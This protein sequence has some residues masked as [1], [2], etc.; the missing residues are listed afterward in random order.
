MDIRV[1]HIPE[2]ENIQQ[3]SISIT[4][5][6]RERGDDIIQ[7]Y[8]S[9]FRQTEGQLVEMDGD[10]YSLALERPLRRSQPRDLTEEEIAIRRIRHPAQVAKTT[11][12]DPT[13]ELAKFWIQSCI[14]GHS[15]CSDGAGDGIYLP[16][17][18][19]DLGDPQVVRVI[20]T[21][22]STEDVKYLTLSHCWGC[23]R[24]PIGVPN[25]R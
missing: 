21:A 16:T 10:G 15:R 4:R 3:F 17:R 24:T 11:A 25:R 22:K 1:S 9:P 20:E 19:V 13:I 5:Q 23:R 8:I 7:V 6:R 18:L 2:L 12:S 14:A